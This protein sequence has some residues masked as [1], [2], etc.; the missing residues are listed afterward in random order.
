MS[1]S[2]QQGSKS[3]PKNTRNNRNKPGGKSRPRGKKRE[4]AGLAVRRAGVEILFRILRDGEAFDRAFANVTSQDAV[5]SMEHRDRALIRLLVTTA[6]RRRGQIEDVL[7]HFIAKGLPKRSGAVSEILH[8]AVVQILFLDTPPHA[9]INIAVEQC[10]MDRRGQHLAKLANAV[11]RRVAEGGGEIIAAQDE[12]LLNTP[13]WLMKRLIAS[14][15]E[16][17]AHKIAA[18]HQ[19]TPALDISVKSD[20]ARWVELLD[21]TELPG[22]SIRIEPKGRVEDLPGYDAGEWWVQDVAATLPIKMLGDVRGL[23]VADLCAAPGGKTMMLAALGADVWAVDNSAERLK[24]VHENLERLQLNANVIE[25]DVMT[26]VPGAD[27]APDQDDADSAPDLDGVDSAPDQDNAGFDVVVLDAPCSATGT[28][29]R[30]PD[31]PHIKKAQDAVV[32]AKIQ[33]EMLV[34]ACDLVKPGGRLIFCTCSLD[35]LEGEAHL[36]FVARELP[37]LEIQPIDATAMGWPTEWIGKEGFV[38]TL[39]HYLSNDGEQ[40]SG[41]DGFF[42]VKFIKKAD[43]SP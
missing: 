17:V 21:G 28:I 10:R 34:H 4:V 26:W 24:R 38:R 7:K 15:G 5:S 37:A 19:T 6:L 30:H 35:A 36:D 13:S 18:A 41:M 16:G 42:A 2:D 40:L 39:P 43:A 8:V 1:N 14:F 12:V 31:I 32:L 22:G 29:R 23:R 33:Q 11:L 25:A 9:A 3:P 20:T 27:I